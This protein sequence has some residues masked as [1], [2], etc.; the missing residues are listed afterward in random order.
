MLDRVAI[1]TSDTPTISSACNSF[2]TVPY[3][4]ETQ[5]RSPAH[6]DLVLC[7]S[8]AAMSTFDI[9]AIL[10]V[11][12]SDRTEW[13]TWSGMS[14]DDLDTDSKPA[15]GTPLVQNHHTD[16]ST[17]VGSTGNEGAA[18]ETLI[19]LEH[20]EGCIDDTTRVSPDVGFCLEFGQQ[21]EQQ[22]P[23]DSDVCSRSTEGGCSSLCV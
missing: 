16:G 20:S 17:A 2:N 7:M 11:L 21:T 5:A 23:L 13:L 14:S 18:A 19:T 12:H 22:C 6:R 1:T 15:D 10:A 8:G 9:P 4:P 3:S